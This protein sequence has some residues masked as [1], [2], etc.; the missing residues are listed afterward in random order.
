MEDATAHRKP[1]EVRICRL[2]DQTALSETQTAL[3]EANTQA[4]QLRDELAAAEAQVSPPQD[5]D[6]DSQRTLPA[7]LKGARLLYV[8]GCPEHIPRI[9][10][11]VEEAQAELLHHDGGVEDRKG[12][13]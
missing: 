3:R 11:F 7:Y 12:L 10:A 1:P 5:T 4:Q 8:G 6:V 13:L 9:R 2:R